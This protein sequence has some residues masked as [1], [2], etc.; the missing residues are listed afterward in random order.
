MYSVIAASQQQILD[1]IPKRYV[2][3][4][5]QLCRDVGRAGT[6]DYQKQ[7]KN[8]WEMN[9][10][11]GGFCT[12]YFELLA[13]PTTPNLPGLL[14]ALEDAS[15]RRDEARTVQFSFATKLLHT[16][17]PQLPIYD[18]RVARFFL[19]ERPLGADRMARLIAFYDFLAGEYARI[20]DAG[21]LADAISAFRQKFNLQQHSDEKIIDWLIWAFVGLMDRGA[22]LERL[23]VYK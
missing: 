23:I 13:A 17:N 4:Y 3:D 1:S 14:Q 20:I 8:F 10:A 2:E 12:K 16:R 15:M 11:S 5:E 21:Y 9:R 18:S 22:L 19:F 7:Y 6:E